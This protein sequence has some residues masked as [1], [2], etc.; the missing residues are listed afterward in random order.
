MK[1]KLIVLFPQKFTQFEYF[2]FEIEK[3]KKLKY[4]VDIIDLSKILLSKSFNKAWKSIRS[5]YAIAPNS[6]LELYFCLKRNKENSIILSFL[7]NN[8]TLKICIIFFIIQILKIKQIFIN[9]T[10]P[11]TKWR[12]KNIIYWFISKLKQHKFNFRV[13]FFYLQY[14]V[15]K[16]LM[17]FLQ[18][19]K[20]FFSNLKLK[21]IKK[22][23]LINFYDYSSSLEKSKI[24]KPYK[25][26][27]L[28]LDN[29][30]PYFFGDAGLIG[31]K[32][33]T[34]DIKKIYADI[35]FFFKKIE[36]DFNC[37]VIIIPHPKYKSSQVNY[38][39]NPYFR[40]FKVDN[41]P[42]AL[43]IL[44]KNAKF[45]LARGSTANSYAVI[46]KKPIINFYSF[47]F[48]YNFGDQADILDIIDKSK[49]LG[50]TAFNI[51]NYSKKLFKEQLKVSLSSY[52]RYL[53][54]E[55]THKNT[56]NKPNYKIISEYIEKARL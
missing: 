5:K 11:S 32:H 40:N 42:D 23:K 46:Y 38:S 8:Y 47:D 56:F 2:K 39:L 13:Y 18:N 9:D 50:K 54:T 30:G 14:L 55:L 26:Y 29:G 51:N 33:P 49:S 25:S 12:S 37:K 34:Y 17:I 10:H 28:Y 44:T 3:Y 16:F 31:A 22:I 36:S 53:F 6:I 48:I 24:E 35:I 4:K 41:R 19:P 43:V 20:V 7:A 52:K 15:S 21:N 27:C 1:K 45:L